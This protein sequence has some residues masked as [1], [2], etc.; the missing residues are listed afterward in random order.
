MPFIATVGALNF[1]NLVN[2]KKIDFTYSLSV[3]ES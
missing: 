3:K 2:F 1:I